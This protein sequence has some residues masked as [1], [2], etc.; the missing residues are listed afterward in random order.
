M[1]A[2][3]RSDH[4]SGSPTDGGARPLIIIIKDRLKAVSCA[5]LVLVLLW[6]RPARTR[7]FVKFA[8]WILNNRFII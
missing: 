8:C 1:D 5:L 4:L 6:E 3:S 7:V 2:G